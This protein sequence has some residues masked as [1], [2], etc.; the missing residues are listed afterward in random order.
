MS[1]HSHGTHVRAPESLYL[2]QHHGHPGHTKRVV[3]C[4][5]CWHESTGHEPHEIVSVAENDAVLGPREG[6]MSAPED[7]VGTF[8]K[9]ILEAVRGEEPHHM[10]SV[11]D[12]VAAVCVDDFDELPKRLLGTRDASRGRIMFTMSVHGQDRVAAGVI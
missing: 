7:E 8:T 10:R 3:V 9:R 5:Q 2:K 6:P 12:E 1:I 4:D 11:V